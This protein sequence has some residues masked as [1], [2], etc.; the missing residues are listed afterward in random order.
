MAEAAR[1]MAETATSAM[2]E[3]AIRGFTRLRFADS[4]ADSSPIRG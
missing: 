2:A 3:A 1:A 4:V